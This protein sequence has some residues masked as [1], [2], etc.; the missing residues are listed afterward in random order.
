MIDN[1]MMFVV[2]AMQTMKD[3]GRVTMGIE[4]KGKKGKIVECGQH[5]YT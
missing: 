2:L 3:S 1:E 4:V 5:L